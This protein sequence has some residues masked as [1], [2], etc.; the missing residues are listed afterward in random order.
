MNKLLIS[1]CVPILEQEYDM[2]IPI[3]KKIGTV[4]RVIVEAVSE[5]SGGY[6]VNKENLKLYDRKSGV[7][8]DNDAMV[9]DS[10]IQNGT[11]MLLL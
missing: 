5:M 7:C 9:K 2:R 6:L 1:V 11:K 10:N 4:R 8:Y 3:N